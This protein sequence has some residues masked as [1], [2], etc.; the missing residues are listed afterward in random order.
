MKMLKTLS[1]GLAVIGL[2]SVTNAG[3]SLVAVGNTGTSG[4]WYQEFND[5]ELVNFDKIAVSWVS[6]TVFEP[7][8]IRGLSGAGWTAVLGTSTSDSA[9]GTAL[10]NLNF[11]M[12]WINSAAAPTSFDF[13]AYNGNV[14]VDSA[15]A[16]WVANTQGAYEWDVS[17]IPVPEP[18]T[19]IA[20]AL[21]LLPFGASAFR[22]LRRN[23]IG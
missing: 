11:S 7:T 18:T 15:R 12:N 5:S 23:R 10:N 22:I 19:V 1:T 17:T 3:A 21:L 13:Y 6:G 8:A 9:S 20:G 16:S 4:S 14:L 2:L